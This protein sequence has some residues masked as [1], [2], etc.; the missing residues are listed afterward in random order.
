MINL[1]QST[2]EMGS[3]GVMN[4]VLTTPPRRAQK[5]ALSTLATQSSPPSGQRGLK[6][7]SRAQALKDYLKTATP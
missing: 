7:H 5:L 3:N 1:Q 2:H 4:Q 6:R